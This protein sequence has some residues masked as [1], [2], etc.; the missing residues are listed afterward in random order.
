MKFL[1]VAGPAAMSLVGGGIL[2]HGVALLHHA[3]QALGH[4]AGTIP[5]VGAVLGGLG[6]MLFN[7]FVGVVAGAI[8]LAAVTLVQKVWRRTPAR[9]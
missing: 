8:V 5:G 6:E 9:A 3:V 2:V 4:A 7:A 1:S